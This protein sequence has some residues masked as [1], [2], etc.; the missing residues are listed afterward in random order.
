[1]NFK[2]IT[3]DSLRYPF[4]SNKLFVLFLLNLGYLLIIPGIIAGGYVIR[5]IESTLEGSKE[6]PE[7]TDL[8][9]LLIDGLKYIVVGF[10]YGIPVLIVN[11]II[12]GFIVNHDTAMNIMTMVSLILGFFIDVILLMA[13]AN[14]VREKTIKGAFQFKRIFYLIKCISWKKYLAFLIIYTIITTLLF[15]IMD[16]VSSMVV[17]SNVPIILTDI[18]MALPDYSSDAG[19]SFLIFVGI[20]NTYLAA[21]TGRFIGLIYPKS[22]ENDKER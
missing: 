11:S 6:L 17:F 10:I 18:Y 5:I 8:K 16:L 12:W 1:M 21:F 19:I 4:T 9:K 22:F 14:M 3:T 20:I 13:L 7:F 2:K 15:Q